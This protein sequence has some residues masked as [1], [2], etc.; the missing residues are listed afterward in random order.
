MNS[1]SVQTLFHFIS[2]DIYCNY[3]SEV[4]VTNVINF[5]ICFRCDLIFHSIN[6]IVSQYSGSDLR[7]SE[8]TDLFV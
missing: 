4:K 5:H 7:T 1:V 8:P 2:H 3:F 6:Y